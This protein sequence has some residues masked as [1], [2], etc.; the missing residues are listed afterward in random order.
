M[1]TWSALVSVHV[2]PNFVDLLCLDR[3]VVCYS[4]VV[5]VLMQE[6]VPF[7]SATRAGP[8]TA[9]E[10]TVACIGSGLQLEISVES[11]VLQLR[12]EQKESLG[13]DVRWHRVV[14]SAVCSRAHERASAERGSSVSHTTPLPILPA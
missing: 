12:N 14:A 6:R 7:W 11:A 13:S 3:H 4:C 2:V 5:V 10:K 8:F 9:L 1:S